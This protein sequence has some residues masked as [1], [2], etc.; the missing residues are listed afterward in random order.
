MSSSILNSKIRGKK[1]EFLFDDENLISI[2]LSIIWAK[3]NKKIESCIFEKDRV[4]LS[5][6]KNGG[7][8]YFDLQKSLSGFTFVDKVKR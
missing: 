4:K 2:A 1:V 7:R 8:V 3:T 6:K 5:Y